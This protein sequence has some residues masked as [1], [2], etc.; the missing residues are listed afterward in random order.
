MF[1]IVNCKQ[2]VQEMNNKIQ[3]MRSALEMSQEELAKVS[4]VSRTVISQLESGTRKTITSAT[5]LR[6][7]KALKRPVEDIFLF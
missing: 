2:E 3:E 4:G 7:S 5:M 1:T 6:L